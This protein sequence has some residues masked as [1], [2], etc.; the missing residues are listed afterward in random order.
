MTPTPQPFSFL[1]PGGEPLSAE[2]DLPVG[3]PRAFALFTHCFACDGDLPAARLISE[4]LC[5]RGFAVLRV[6]ENPA[7]STGTQELAAILVSA[8][9]ELAKQ[10]SLPRLLVGHSRG[11]TAVL[12]AAAEL[13][14]TEA[15]VTIGAPA[16]A[17]L[18][19]GE[20]LRLDAGLLVMHSP[21]DKVVAID[22]ARRIYEGVHGFKSF[23]SLADA[24]HTLSL[25]ED[26]DYVGTMIAS[27]A[28]RY[29]SFASMEERAPK[30]GRVAVEE[31]DRP[32]TNRVL[33]RRHTW[34]ADEPKEL[35]GLD[36]GPNPYELLL[37]GLGAC[38]SMTLRMYAARKRWPLEHVR[39]ELA[40]S[41]IHAE[42]CAEC[43]TREG[44][45]DRIERV[46]ELR[47]DL[48][49][50]QRARLLEIADRCPVHRTLMGEKE[51]RTSL[52]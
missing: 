44:H 50:D 15:V 24:D 34:L 2:L 22:E 8:A 10:H 47:G 31:W 38:T 37:A 25:R 4:A 16:P 39:V 7:Q 12:E 29:V 35:G 33:A 28:H 9:K 3:P 21:V 32:Y 19:E 46:I 1:G 30:E 42:D 5:R 43:E 41:K 20:A 6:Q 11:G 49:A 51:V 40:H 45:V 13:P 26:A 23:L 52:A 27:W 48:D 17:A 14:A 36:A 18:A